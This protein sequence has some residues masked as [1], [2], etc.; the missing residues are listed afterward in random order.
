MNPQLREVLGSVLL[1]EIYGLVDWENEP[2]EV[3]EQCMRGAE[4]VVEM[5][6]QWMDENAKG[7]LK[8]AGIGESVHSTDDPLVK[9]ERFDW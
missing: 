8:I 2:K 9:A 6:K 3:R 4:K 1:K 5:Y 7:Y